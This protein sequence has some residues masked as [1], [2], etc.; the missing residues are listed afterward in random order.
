MASPPRAPEPVA[1]CAVNRPKDWL[2]SC[3]RLVMLWVVPWILIVATLHTAPLFQTSAWVV[4]FTVMGI[5]CWINARQCGRR[6][7]YVTGMAF[8]LAALA[9]L[10]YGLEIL[11]LGRNGWNWIGGAAAGVCLL[12]CCG[13]EGWLGRY[14]TPPVSPP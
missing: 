5:S 2:H 7:C 10:L 12:A 3:S 1:D 13:L 11:P 14:F 6:H 9:S 4:G 8:L